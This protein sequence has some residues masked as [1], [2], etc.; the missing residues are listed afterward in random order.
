MGT[1]KRN[2]TLLSLRFQQI[3]SHL[4]TW[5]SFDHISKQENTECDTPQHN[6][7][8]SQDKNKPKIILQYNKTKG[9]VVAM[10]QMVHAFIWNRKTKRW[11]MVIF[12]NMVDL[13]STAS[14]ASLE[15]NFQWN[16]YLTKTTVR[17]SIWKPAKLWVL[18]QIMPHAPISTLQEPVRQNI[19]IVLKTL[20]PA[21]T[22]A[23]KWTKKDETAPKRQ[24]RCHFCPTKR[25]C[26][27]KSICNGCH[28]HIYQE[29][30]RLSC[31]HC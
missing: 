21:G 8:V 17:D 11:L 5:D 26:K 28:H 2:K 19:S 25:D 30:S 27:T 4:Q 16:S 9:R 1:V 31:L 29:P 24:K 20:L 18:A 13:T 23:P 3:S 15:S 12:F 10:D 14:S 6:A 22:S 7:K